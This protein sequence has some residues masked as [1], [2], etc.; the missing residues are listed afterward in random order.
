MPV[1]SACSAETPA[2]PEP[3]SSMCQAERLAG[4]VGQD[5]SALD[6]LDPALKASLR[7]L[8][9]DGMVDAS[10]NPDRTNVTIGEDGTIESI[11]C[12]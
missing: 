12:F 3:L 8:Q 7:V 11:R 10:Y 4:L 2:A 5:Q 9:S 1:L 6:Q